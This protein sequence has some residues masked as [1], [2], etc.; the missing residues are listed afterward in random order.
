MTRSFTLSRKERRYKDQNGLCHY[1]TRLMTYMPEHG[2][3]KHV[4]ATWDH[5]TPKSRGGDRSYENLVLACYDCNMSKG[6]TTEAEFAE[7]ARVAGGYR[8][9]WGRCLI[10]REGQGAFISGTFK[11]GEILG[12]LLAQLAQP[13]TR[14]SEC[15]A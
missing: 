5:R 12:P 3:G 1:C 2:V 11:L 4:V 14:W 8:H 9:L 7:A 13:E 10:W 6:N 15:G